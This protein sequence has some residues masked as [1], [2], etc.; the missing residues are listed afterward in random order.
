MSTT[1]GNRRTWTSVAPCQSHLALQE[2]RGKNPFICTCWW[3][4]NIWTGMEQWINVSPLTTTK[5]LVSAIKDCRKFCWLW[6]IWIKM[7]KNKHYNFVHVSRILSWFLI[8]FCQSPLI[9]LYVDQNKFIFKKH[10][11]VQTFCQV[12]PSQASFV[13]KIMS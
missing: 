3:Q 13:L 5:V 4:K 1:G 9:N 11:N 8:L 7:T 12:N 10:L 2:G 6:K